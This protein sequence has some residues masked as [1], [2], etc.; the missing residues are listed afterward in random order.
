MNTIKIQKYSE[1]LVYNPNFFDGWPNPPSIKT[2]DKILKNSYLS[3]LAIDENTRTVVGF[4]NV[5]SDGILSAY[6][7]LLEVIKN[8]QGQGIGRRLV[9]TTL[10]D[11][12][13]LY[14]IDLSCDDNLVEFY[15][16]LGLHQGNLMFKRN[17]DMQSGSLD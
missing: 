2:L 15:K 8:Y 1:H 11:L 6:I 7:P 4:I 3:Y 12:E 16:G 13:H 9:E 5:I 17:Y 14:M 10:K